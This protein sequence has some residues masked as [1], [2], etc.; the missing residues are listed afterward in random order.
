[1]SNEAGL[2]IW[3][4]IAVSQCTDQGIHTGFVCVNAWPAEF[5]RE[6]RQNV[7]GLAIL[8]LDMR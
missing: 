1:M 3:A 7:F 5:S 6:F 4:D 8:R 2:H